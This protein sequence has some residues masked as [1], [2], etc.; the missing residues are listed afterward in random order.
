VRSD[1]AHLAQS[2]Q[3]ALLGA[4]AL[5]VACGWRSAARAAAWSVLAL[6]SWLAASAANPVLHALRPGA[7]PALVPCEV[8]GER[9]RLA[10]EVARQVQLLEHVVASHVPAEEL[11]FLAPGLT[12]F[13]P[14]LG[15]VSPVWGIYFLWPASEAEQEE[16]VRQLEER[17]LSW[18]L[19]KEAPPDGRAELLFR[20]T[21]PLVWRWLGR[22]FERIPTPELPE[23]Y[24]LLRRRER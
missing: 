6:G 7:R 10:P 19:I 21:H 4:L 23:N 8:A 12:T 1:A 20:N 9:L 13:Y 5:P 18:A 3:P 22:V 11:L 16:L 17:G 2:L 14:V 15:R 24:F